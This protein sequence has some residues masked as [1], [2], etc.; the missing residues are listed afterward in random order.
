M[1]RA[2]GAEG[3]APEPCAPAP[4][5]G[6]AR[7]GNE[8]RFGGLLSRTEEEEEEDGGVSYLLTTV[9]YAVIPFDSRGPCFPPDGPGQGADRCRKDP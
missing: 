1:S 4:G 2:D 5:W 9:L 3:S 8:S 6:V 7:E